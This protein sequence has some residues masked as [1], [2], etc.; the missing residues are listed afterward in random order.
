MSNDGSC[1]GAGM[2]PLPAR[3][4]LLPSNLLSCSTPCK[5]PPPAKTWNLE[6]RP[7][8]GT[9]NLPRPKCG[10]WNLGPKPKRGTWNL[11]VQT[12]NLSV[13][14]WNLEPRPRAKTW[15][16]EPRPRAKTIGST[17]DLAA[18]SR[19]FSERPIALLIDILPKQIDFY[20]NES[21]YGE[22]QR[23]SPRGML[24]GLYGVWCCIAVLPYSV[25]WDCMA[26]W[27]RE[28]GVTMREGCMGQYRAVWYT[29]WRCCCMAR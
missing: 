9:W 26:V 20:Q 21:E 29:V 17:H 13:Q 14:T 23:A 10:T 15:N 12:W 22:K 2:P 24:Y 7:K 19:P 6:P 28:A 25:V 4:H 8:R 5:V 18:G 3:T 1:A 27:R 11:S 16:L